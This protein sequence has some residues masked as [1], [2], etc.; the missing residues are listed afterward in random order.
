MI[1]VCAKCNEI[2]LFHSISD[3]FVFEF[4]DRNRVL[5]WKNINKKRDIMC[6]Q[7]IVR[8]DIGRSFANACLNIVCE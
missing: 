8:N 6:I 4:T 3:N 5:I 2:L 1:H 7:C